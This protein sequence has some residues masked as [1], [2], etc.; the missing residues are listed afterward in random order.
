MTV[1]HSCYNA[2]QNSPLKSPLQSRVVSPV[3]TLLLVL[4]VMLVSPQGVF[5]ECK[6]FKIVEYEDR[7]EAV[8][9]GEPLTEAQKK[10]NLED[11]KRQEAAAQRKRLEEQKRQSIS[12][13]AAAKAAVKAADRHGV[14]A[15][16]RARPHRQR[17]RP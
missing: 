5:A 12:D 13:A 4:V 11:E 14:A 17:G 1:P 9:V 6:E 8:C 10:A 3:H 16:P 15:A 2:G 7:V